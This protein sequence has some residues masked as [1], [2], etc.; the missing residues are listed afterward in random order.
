MFSDFSK[1]WLVN[2]ERDPLRLVRITEE[3][4]E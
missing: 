2:L 4:L 3:L 1:K